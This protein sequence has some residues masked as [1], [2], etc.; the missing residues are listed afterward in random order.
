MSLNPSHSISR[1]FPM[2]PLL[3]P[4]PPPPQPPPALTIQNLGLEAKGIPKQVLELSLQHFQ[5]IKKQEPLLSWFQENG[6]AEQVKTL[7]LTKKEE[8]LIHSMFEKWA[9]DNQICLLD[10]FGIDIFEDIAETLN[11]P[12]KAEIKK[13]LVGLLILGY[14]RVILA[15]AI[16][17]RFPN[18]ALYEGGY[19]IRHQ[20]YLKSLK[21]LETVLALVYQKQLTKTRSPQQYEACLKIQQA[22]QDKFS[23]LCKFWKQPNYT[24]FLIDNSLT[25]FSGS[26]SLLKS[27]PRHTFSHL[28]KYLDFFIFAFKWQESCQG[29]TFSSSYYQELRNTLQMLFDKP[30]SLEI[31]VKIHDCFMKVPNRGKLIETFTNGTHAAILGKFTEKEFREVAEKSPIFISGS[32]QSK[33]LSQPQFVAKMAY[34][35]AESCFYAAIFNDFVRIF[36]HRVSPFF[37]PEIPSHHAFPIRIYYVLKH[38]LTIQQEIVPL[39][40]EKVC[41]DIKDMILKLSFPNRNEMLESYRKFVSSFIKE[42]EIFPERLPFFDFARIAALCRS[43]S[44]MIKI[45]NQEIARLDSIREKVLGSLDIYFKSL[46]LLELTNQG[47]GLVVSLKKTTFDC[48]YPI[49]LDTIIFKDIEN[50]L[51]NSI[52]LKDSLSLIPTELA[53][54]ISLEGIDEL[55]NRIIQEKQKSQIIQPLPAL[56]P[57]IPAAAPPPQAAKPAG[58]GRALSPQ[59]QFKLRSGM[60]IRAIA[61]KLKEK[62]ILPVDQTGSHLKF[63]SSTGAVVIVP[64]HKEIKIGTLKNIEKQALAALREE[65]IEFKQDRKGLPRN[66]K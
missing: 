65:K 42:I 2:A 12:Q 55:L 34:H 39:V 5:G 27:D 32:H 8:G 26:H 28:N 17:Q 66:G 35:I 24:L 31:L 14:S 20:D 53:N 16:Q 7:A 61:N 51:N 13:A 58:E 33:P 21:D 41:V 4:L 10:L 60:N 15:P 44:P 38:Q 48:L 30:T 46:S 64:F 56:A 52:A 63:K 9:L 18:I 37:F 29:T 25:R 6:Y 62:G 45:W 23:L 11:P 47:A 54:L 1:S 3:S 19:F 59:E 50:F 57:K 43:C 49:L 36:D 22:V 40:H